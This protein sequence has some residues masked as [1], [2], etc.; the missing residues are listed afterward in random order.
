MSKKKTFVFII[1]AVLVAQA[2][3]LKS[4][5]AASY[6]DFSNSTTNNAEQ[7]IIDFITP[8][9]VAGTEVIKTNVF[10]DGDL[11]HADSNGE[12]EGFYGWANGYTIGNFSYQDEVHAGSYGGYLMAR[13]S[14]QFWADISTSRYFLYI[15]ERSYLDQDINMNFWYN[16]KSN[17]DIAQGANIRIYLRLSTNLG[18]YYMYYYL[19]QQSGLPGNQTNQAYY[20]VR[21]PTNS[22]INLDRNVTD[23]FIQAMGILPDLSLSYIRYMYIT[24]TS[25]DDPTG[26][27]VLLIDDVSFTNGTGFNYFD[28]NGDF[29]D[30]D[31]FPWYNSGTGPGYI[32]VTQADTTQGTGAMNMTTYNPYAFASSYC[33]ADKDIYDDWDN[34][35]SGFI[36]YQPGDMTI[37]FDWKYTDQPGLGRQRTQFYLQ[38]R[39]ETFSSTIHF[40]L[41]DENDEVSQSNYTASTYAHWYIKAPDFGVRN[42]WNHFS[43]DFYDL[44]NELNYT[45]LVAY[46]VTFYMDI[47]GV[48]DLTVQLLVDDFQI[49][50]YPAGDPGFEYGDYQFSDPIRLWETVD[51]PYY[52][53]ITTDA[54]SGIY[55]ANLSSYIGI[56]QSYARRSTFLPVVNNLYTDFWWRLDKITDNDGDFTYS[57]IKLEVDGSRDIYYMLASNDDFMV[58]NSSNVCYYFVDNFNQTGT[59]YN[60]F[61]NLTEDVSEAFGPGNWNITHIWNMA[62][63][64]GTSEITVI[65][66]DLHFVT[67]VTGPILTNLNQDPVAPQ[68]FEDVTITVDVEDNI[69]LDRVRFYYQIDDGFITDGIMAFN[70]INYEYTI[71]QQPFDTTINYFIRAWDIYG[72]N[73]NLGDASTPYSSYVVDDLIDPLLYIWEQPPTDTILAGNVLFDID[74]VDLGSG[75]ADFEIHID[76]IIVLNDTLPPMQFTW[77]TEDYENGIHSISFYLWDG[78]GN[79]MEIHFQYEIYNPPTNWEAFTTFMQKWGPYIGGGAGGLAIIVVVL[80]VVLKRKK[81][82]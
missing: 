73:T 2:I 54:H 6:S 70:G 60:I 16:A 11:D 61:R 22:W 15:S 67:D 52:A 26:D 3:I 8:D 9:A 62:Y 5:F 74:A 29:E 59:W 27:T 35:P 47:S 65:L 58:S 21:G 33:Y 32:T 19:S 12:P 51:D 36:G 56:T 25:P 55:A 68:Y 40:Y 18:N 48:E 66:D 72:H 77:G 81:G 43:I 82:I 7:P 31:E 34:V 4:N 53:N 44:M 20:D 80:V 30:G 38:A 37:E 14:E 57:A 17:P 64:G 75:I 50:T 69:E 79:S 28:N 10:E 46:Y 41:G 49:N 76:D 45:N 63:A 42:T 1:M 23:D 78:A 13:G 24:A 39:N 71:P